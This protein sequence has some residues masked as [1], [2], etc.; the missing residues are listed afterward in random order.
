MKISV[1]TMHIDIF[2]KKKNGNEILEEI[3]LYF[4]SYV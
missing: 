2:T 3:N 1:Y 4:E